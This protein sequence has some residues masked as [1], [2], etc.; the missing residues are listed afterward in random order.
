MPG[1]EI[2]Q[3]H[4]VYEAISTTNFPKKDASCRIGE[5]THIWCFLDEMPAK[6]IT[7]PLANA[8]MFSDTAHHP[9]TIAILLSSGYGSAANMPQRPCP[10]DANGAPAQSCPHSH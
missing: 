7:F 8:Y 3:Q 1:Y 2:L 4:T 10:P 5:E 9:D 6:P